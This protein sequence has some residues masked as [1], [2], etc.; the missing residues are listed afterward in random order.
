MYRFSKTNVLVKV[1]SFLIIQSFLFTNVSWAAGNRF[2]N[3]PADKELLSP[4][5]EISENFFQRH[6]EVIFQNAP[7]RVNLPKGPVDQNWWEKAILEQLEKNPTPWGYDPLVPVDDAS[8]IVTVNGRRYIPITLTAKMFE[9][10]SSE[11]PEGRNIDASNARFESIAPQAIAGVRGTM[12]YANQHDTRQIK[13]SVERLLTSLALGL[14]V[15]IMYNKGAYFPYQYTYGHEV[16]KH[17]GFFQQVTTQ[18]LTAM[19]FVGHV[20]PDNVPTAI[21]NTSTM[22]KGFNLPL[23]FCGTASHAE[24]EIDG[25]KIM[26]YEGSQF[27]ISTIEAMVKVRQAIIA[28][29]K[30]EGKLTF[31]LAAED[32]ARITD[33]LYRNTHNGMAVYRNYQEA[34]TAEQFILNLIS[35]LDSSK[36]HIDCMHGSGYRTLSAFFREMGMGDLV[37]KLHWMHTEEKSDFG[38]IGKIKVNPK[39][40][41]EQ[42]FDLGADGTQVYEAKLEDGT[43]V[44]YFPVLCTADYQ[45]QFAAMPMYDIILPT[46]MDN[47]RLY[48][49]QI[50][51]NNENTKAILDETGVLYNV[52]NREKLAA[53]FIPNKSFH[54]LNDM[55]F[56]RIIELMKNGKI[57]KNRTIVMFKTLA[58]TP[59][60]DEFME[61]QKKALE[62]KGYKVAVVN[63][64]VGFA[65]LANLMYRSEGFMREHPGEDV[66]LYDATGKPINV[67][68]NP[69]LLSAWEESGG[70]IVGVVFGFQDLMGNAFLAEREKSATESIFLSLA[71]ISEAQKA[72]KAQGT[73]NLAECLKVLYD[74]D[75]VKTPIDLRLDNKLFVPSTSEESVIEEAEGNQRKNR[76]FGAYLSLA[77]A[78]MRGKLTIDQARTIV[79]DLH[80]QEYAARMDQA[81]RKEK[82]NNDPEAVFLSIANNILD[83]K[84]DDNAQLQEK[85]KIIFAL[86]QEVGRN[87]IK[88]ILAGK[89]QDEVQAVLDGKAE[90]A[91]IANEITALGFLEDLM[92]AFAREKRQT[93]GAFDRDL[94]VRFKQLNFDYLQDVW[95]TGDGV[96]FV[97]ENQAE[98]KRWLVLFRPS[99]TEPKLKSYGFGKDIE[100]LTIDTWSFGFNENVAGELP[101]SFK[102]VGA[103]MEIWGEDGE[104]AVDKGRRMQAAWEDYGQ[105]VDPEDLSEAEL[106]ELQ[107][108]KLVRSFSPPDDHIEM[109]NQWLKDKGLEPM[110]ITSGINQEHMPAMMQR[111]IIGLLEVI[112]EDVYN[113]LGNKK[114]DVLM[115][116]RTNVSWY[117][118]ALIQGCLG[119]YFGR[120]DENGVA[121]VLVLRGLNNQEQPLVYSK[122]EGALYVSKEFDDRIK[123]KL[124]AESSKA[125]AIEDLIKAIQDMLGIN[126]IFGNLAL[127]GHVVSKDFITPEMI[128]SGQLAK[129]VRA[130]VVHSSTTN[131]SS[132][133]GVWDLMVN[134]TKKWIPLIEQ[135]VRDGMSAQ[136]IYDTLFIENLVVPAMKIFAPVNERTGYIHGYVSYEFRPQFTAD[137]DITAESNAQEF[138]AQVQAALNELVRIDN[139][140]MEKSGGQHNFFL[141]V[142][143]THV[144]VEAGKRAIALGL[145]INFTLIATLEQYVACVN[146]YKKGVAEYVANGQ[147]RGKVNESPHAKSVASDFVSRTDRSIDTLLSDISKLAGHLKERLD[148]GYYADVQEKEKVETLYGEYKKLLDL[149]DHSGKMTGLLKDMERLKMQSGLAYAIGIIYQR[150]QQEFVN[151]AQWNEFAKANNVPLQQ[152]YWGSTGVKVDGKYTANPHYAGPLRLAGT[153]NTAPPD[154]VDVIA[155]EAPFDGKV[156]IPDFAEHGR[157]LEELAGLG[158]SLALVQD[159]VYRDGLVAFAKDDEATFDGIEGFISDVAA[160]N[161]PI[162][163]D[164]A[165]LQSDSLGELKQTPEEIAAINKRLKDIQMTMMFEDHDVETEAGQQKQLANWRGWVYA[166]QEWA[167]AGIGDTMKLAQLIRDDNTEAF[168]VVGVGGSDQTTKA[169]VNGSISS[170]HN[171][172]SKKARGGAPQLYYTGDGFDPNSLYDI[173]QV[174]DEQGILFKTKFNIISKSGTTA[175]T[176]STFLLIK[177]HLEYRL[178]QIKEQLAQSKI[179]ESD[180]AALG[181]TVK[182]LESVVLTYKVSTKKGQEEKEVKEGT[183]RTGRFFVFTT[184]QNEKSAL[185]NYVKMINEQIDD[186]VYGMLPVPDGTGGRYSFATAVGMLAMG[187]TAN[188]NKGETAENR[189]EEVLQAVADVRQEILNGDIEGDNVLPFAIARANYLAE[190]NHGISILVIYPFANLMQEFANLMMQLSTESIQEQG[191]GLTILPGVGPKLNHSIVNGTKSG[192]RDKIVCFIEVAEFDQKKDGVITGGKALGGSLVGL[193]GFRQS[194]VQHA[195]LDGT[196]EDHI[197][198]GVPAYKITIPALTPYYLAKLIAYFEHEVAIEGQLRGLR[199]KPDENGVYKDLTYL[200]SSVEGYKRRTRARL[201]EMKVEKAESMVQNTAVEAIERSI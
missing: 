73:V 162:T 132:N 146:A 74:R 145:N 1:I 117:H 164:T 187:V 188:E 198:D 6:F 113:Q 7:G 127:Q 4:I 171:S 180:L 179:K 2:L 143:A 60:A 199:Q 159:N 75:D 16:R 38:N 86:N 119:Q 59:A 186:D 184:G 120:D 108:R 77:I 41:A 161:E 12:N 156:A 85:L 23:S 170:Q 144:G 178:A 135:M 26:D 175:E 166:E 96:M 193:E 109:V 89:I 157:I 48:Y 152:I 30:Q 173:L 200:Q 141:K 55:N 39:T 107:K 149:T 11:N 183:F 155:E 128:E 45:E 25:L 134:K 104:K 97:F 68:S 87:G 150:F 121:D 181:L 40:G 168:V 197:E 49:V 201:S 172:L 15:K 102:N 19:G 10:W 112:P 27:P 137:P 167:N 69:I 126:P 142:P 136:E 95:F 92:D 93:K 34:T 101:Q 147:K 192:P 153:T 98:N 169:I 158:I 91:D 90:Y 9:D 20:V 154:V 80:D 182:D 83:G 195:S 110:S 36:V 31:F 21:W 133:K 140:I 103:L 151:D 194:D 53:V 42:I 18:S 99:G 64:A 50:L 35:T 52:V 196:L 111:F 22:G 139:L 63:T 61:A 5:L 174:L 190:T 47:D 78:K 54:F 82:I 138:E 94:I 81:S 72:S 118:S 100:R 66:I 185:Y 116:E 14:M 160:A 67:G 129:Q 65:K 79:K 123:Q 29:V 62:K 37:E 148:K 130:Q 33:E 163:I 125:E 17:S 13:N 114:Q 124:S 32:D 3:T 44:K 24:S 76:I 177:S 43:W 57:D 88:Q 191:Q 165:T 106:E 56:R 51:P 84:L 46:D 131:P 28:K 115:S 70:I 71:F 122:E 105:V 8:K 58:S 189:I 176:A